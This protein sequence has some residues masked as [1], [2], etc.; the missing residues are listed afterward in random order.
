[1]SAW[2]RTRVGTLRFARSR[3]TSHVER[4]HCDGSESDC[5]GGPALATADGAPPPRPHA[6]TE[7]THLLS[8]LLAAALDGHELHG[9]IEDMTGTA[10]AHP[11]SGPAVTGAVARRTVLVT[12]ARGAAT[13][14]RATVLPDLSAPPPAP[15]DLVPQAVEL[16]RYTGALP[17]HTVLEPL[18]FA[19][20]LAEF[21]AVAL[22]AHGP[23]DVA[24][25][26]RHW[27]GT[28]VGVPALTVTD[29]PEALGGWPLD[30]EGTA[31]G[32]LPLV[33]DGTVVGCALD[34][35]GADAL[36]RAP[37]G[38]A[39]RQ[40]L[41][42]AA[43]PANLV[44]ELPPAPAVPEPHLRVERVHYVSVVDADTGTLTA[45]T[46]DLTTVVADGRAVGAV[47]SVRFTV[48]VPSLL[49]S[50]AGGLGPAHT[51]PVSW[52]GCVV[53]S[54]A[55]LATDLPLLSTA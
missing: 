11:A 22:A 42:L 8:A 41:G 1:M 34:R 52:G 30:S 31:A 53:R 35:A 3:V 16:P 37:T 6:A 13:R 46:R 43:Y 49:R 45:A 32:R 40:V 29:N 26:R 38:H 48:R 55:V 36:G 51:V 14:T 17:P 27:D 21:A 4:D 20:L 5:P 10:G 15:A 23:D 47:P 9:R 24:R 28:R 18:A 44:V 12:A 39:S 54:P 2:R 25:F 19:E 33:E 50:L 7:R